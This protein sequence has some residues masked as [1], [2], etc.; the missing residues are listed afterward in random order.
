MNTHAQSQAVKGFLP[1]Q[2]HGILDYLTGLLLI[3]SPWLFG[4]SDTRNA[5]ALFIPI[6]LGWL[7]LILSL[8]TRYPM[9]A[10]KVVPMQLHLTLDVLAGFILAVLPFLYGFYHELVWPHLLIGLFVMLSSLFTQSSPYLEPL[11]LLDS[12]GRSEY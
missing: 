9:G 4:F 8:F 12:R 2:V 7:E 5:A 11:S 3:A 10:F 1:V 6:I